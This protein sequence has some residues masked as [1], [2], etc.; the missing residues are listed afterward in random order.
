L[1]V[2]T[3]PQKSSAK[4]TPPAGPNIPRTSAS[5]E[6]STTT[7][8]TV[9]SSLSHE[10]SSQRS[11]NDVGLATSEPFPSAA[12][13]S[14]M[15]HTGP[16][17]FAPHAGS[18]MP[19][20]DNF[21]RDIQHDLTEMYTPARIAAL[22]HS[23]QS[24]SLQIPDDTNMPGLSH[25]QENSPWCSSASDSNYSTHSDGSRTGGQWSGRARSDSAHTVPNWPAAAPQFPSNAALGT[26][27]DLQSPQFESPLEQFLGPYVSPRMTRP[28]VSQQL[29]DVTNSLDPF[30]MDSV[31]TPT[32]SI[33]SKPLAS[34]LSESTS[35]VS[36]SRLA[37]VDVKTK[38]L[39]EPQLEALYIS[40]TMAHLAP[41][42]PYISS[43]WQLFDAIFP[44]IHRGSFD[45][46]ANIILSSAMAAIGTQYHS[47]A[48]ARQKGIELNDYCRKTI[49]HVSFLDLVLVCFKL[50][51]AHSFPTGIFTQCKQYCS[52]RPS[53]VTAVGK[54]ILSCLDNLN[55]F[56]IG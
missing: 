5:V 42:E 25:T 31:G 14:R 53:P 8:S 6:R 34:V 32:L 36:E 30:Y 18:N 55:K 29:L 15:S 16:S 12:P 27:H 22:S 37:G 47:T 35:R 23:S 49:D 28:S 10:R 33:F 38:Q 21:S 54:P 44:V 41:L 9:T 2:A 24:L 20:Q 13:D 39:M 3:P 1:S 46:T 40:A 7:F 17:T 26:P 50:T 45:P 4:P 52:L 43:Y 56:T 11:T 51:K 48:A 19:G